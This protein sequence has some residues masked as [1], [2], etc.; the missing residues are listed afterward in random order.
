MDDDI[1]GV[2]L[3]GGRSRRLGADKADLVVGDRSLLQRTL[4]V[5][6]GARPLVVVGSR[7]PVESVVVWTSEE[8][9]GGGPLAGMRAGLAEV[10]D[11]IALV[12]VL[13]TDHPGLTRA[14][15]VRLV[16]AVRA[17]P[18]SS[19]A[20]LVDHAGAAQWLVGVWRTDVL[21]RAMPDDPRGVSVRSVVTA[22]DPVRVPAVGDEAC[23]VDTPEDL[24]RLRQG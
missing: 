8:P 9:A 17:D 12:A 15:T 23:D 13:A 2:V 6:D 3:A 24:G 16:R 5:L 22:L 21:W 19:G 4:D 1:A 14:T 11:G 18:E 7:R 20:V 10:P